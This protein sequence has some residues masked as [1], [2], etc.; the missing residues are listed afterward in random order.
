MTERVYG[1]TRETDFMQ[2]GPEDA[3]QKVGW[4]TVEANPETSSYYVTGAYA[5]VGDE[6]AVVAVAEMIDAKERVWHTG[7]TRGL[8][9]AC[10]YSILID[11]EH[12]T[13]IMNTDYAHVDLRDANQVAGRVSHTKRDIDDERVH[14]AKGEGELIATVQSTLEGQG[15]R[16]FYPYL[17]LTINGRMGRQLYQQNDV[18]PPA[19]RDIAGVQ[20]YDPAMEDVVQGEMQRISTYNS[21]LHGWADNGEIMV[22]GLADGDVDSELFGQFRRKAAGFHRR[23][24]Q[25]RDTMVAP[26]I[27]YMP[28]GAHRTYP[29][30]TVDD[31]K[32][33]QEAVEAGNLGIVTYAV[34]REAE[35]LRKRQRYALQGAHIFQAL[36]V[37]GRQR[38]ESDL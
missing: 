15:L 2:Y 8:S 36:T 13:R 10:A 20:L 3:G 12:D 25:L 7:L 11:P 28:E 26:I 30:M 31:S 29:Y 35:E 4:V 22:N 27:S 38:I 34:E 6:G 23:I 33:E 9:R 19:L 14:W 5:T 16:D 17:Y 21:A 24:E 18:A 32:P 1:N 37:D